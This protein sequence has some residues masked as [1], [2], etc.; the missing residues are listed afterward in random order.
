MPPDT[1][2][3]L[4]SARW[5][6]PVAPDNRVL[7]DHS[8]VLAGSKILAV[9]PTAAARERWPDV[10]ETRLDRHALLPGLV[11]AHGHAAMSLFRGYADDLPLA[12]WLNERIWPMEGR[13]VDPAFVAEGTALAVAEMVAAGTTTFSDM[14]F[15]PE[16]SAAVALRAGVRAQILGPLVRFPNAWSS[17]A[18]EAIHKSLALHDEYRDSDRIRIAFGP[19]S[20]YAFDPAHLA[21]IAVLAEELD[22]RVQIHLHET[23]DEITTARQETGERPLET[24]ER[25][26]LLGPNLQAVHMTQLEP[27]DPGRLARHDV[28]VIHCP[29]S[30]L[31]LASGFCPVAELRAAGVRVA[32]GT[33]GAASNNSLSL[34]REMHV[35]A[36]LAKAVAADA[37]ALPALEVIRMATLS[38]AEALG[39]GDLTGSLES[40]KAA[41]MVAVDLSGIANEPVFHPE[42]Q[43]VYAGGERGVSTV[44][45]DGAPVYDQG[46]HLRQDTDAIL[47]SVRR[48]R[49]RMQDEQ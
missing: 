31:K 46:R 9:L 1:A 49:N 47:A 41:D 48:W 36:I 25:C 28:S 15:F 5:V 11:N 44:W 7:D 35:A 42:S 4:L 16:A 10:P 37:A 32:L 24:L 19:H 14:Y 2:T 26:G 13:W 18:D 33:D 21:R 30:N 34:F 22:V 12:T 43:L 8:V 23:A 45:V 39:F 17:G 38:G 27:G 3:A 6:L 20:T 29:Q 40:G